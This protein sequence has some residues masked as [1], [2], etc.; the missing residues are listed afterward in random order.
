MTGLILGMVGAGLYVIG[1]WDRELPLGGKRYFYILGAACCESMVIVGVT[2]GDRGYI[3]FL[4]SIVG[5]SLLLASIT[6]ILIRQVYNFVWWPALAAAVLPAGYR[7]AEFVC[8]GKAGDRAGGMVWQWMFFCFLQ[9]TLFRRMYGKADCYA[10]CICAGAE[11]AA[12]LGITEYLIH[13][14]LAYAL[15]IPVQAV[16]RNIEEGGKLKRP[17]P[18]LPYITIAFWLTMI[19]GQ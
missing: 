7:W 10:F 9:L 19:R 3:R 11:A 1:R 2:E 4:L 15:L 12:G 14:F 6:D 5:G 13:M 16:R 18:F 8:Q 17:V